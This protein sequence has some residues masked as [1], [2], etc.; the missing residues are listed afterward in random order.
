MANNVN[1]QNVEALNNSLF[2]DK[3]CEIHEIPQESDQV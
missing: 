2:L 3:I 1:V